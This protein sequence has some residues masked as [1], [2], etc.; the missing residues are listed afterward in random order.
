MPYSEGAAL[1]WDDD[2]EKKPAY[3][4]TLDAIT[5]YEGPVEEPEEPVE[6]PEDPVKCKRSKRSKRSR[7]N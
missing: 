3:Q 6:E 4:A 5:G 7:K 2:Y 1:L